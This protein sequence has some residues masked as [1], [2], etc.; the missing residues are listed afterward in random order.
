LLNGKDK[1]GT[2]AVKSVRQAAA[3]LKSRLDFSGNRCL[4][5]VEGFLGSNGRLDVLEKNLNRIESNRGW[6]ELRADFSRLRVTGEGSLPTYFLAI[7]IKLAL[8]AETRG[9]DW[10]LVLTDREQAEVLHFYRWRS[11]K[12]IDSRIVFL[13][14]QL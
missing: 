13:D 12:S 14:N 11:R 10:Q 8:S 7:V 4:F 1:E 2:M 5:T 9:A 3:V 6:R